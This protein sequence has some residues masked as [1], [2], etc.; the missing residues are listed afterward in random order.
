M[1]NRAMGKPVFNPTAERKEDF[2]DSALGGVE[3][4][5]LRTKDG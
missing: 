4:G 1:S 2:T 3:V 5:K